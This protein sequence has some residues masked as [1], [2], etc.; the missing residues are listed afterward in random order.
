MAES[1]AR[2]GRSNSCPCPCPPHQQELHTPA[3]QKQQF[4]L[5][6]LDLPGTQPGMHDREQVCDRLIAH[7]R[8]E[9]ALVVAVAAAAGLPPACLILDLRRDSACM[10]IAILRQ[11]CCHS[12][13][14][15]LPLHKHLMQ[16]AFSPVVCHRFDARGAPKVHGLDTPRHDPSHSCSD[17]FR[18]CLAAE[19]CSDGCIAVKQNEVKPAT[20]WQ[21]GHQSKSARLVVSE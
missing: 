16:H 15:M 11:Q 8:V 4:E 2:G 6:L 12:A 10:P 3:W 17:T 1:A 14:A 5:V 9:R 13:S 19:L 7:L 20:G 18:N 21:Q